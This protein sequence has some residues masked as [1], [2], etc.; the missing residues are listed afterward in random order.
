LAVGSEPAAVRIH[1]EVPNHL[2]P[3]STIPIGHG[4]DAGPQVAPQTGL[5]LHLAEGRRG[6]ILAVI[7]LALGERP[8][9]VPRTMHE[10]HRSLR[11]LAPQDDASRRADG[12]AHAQ[13]RSRLRESAFHASGDAARAS[14]A[15]CASIAASSPAT[16]ASAPP[17]AASRSHA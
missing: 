7:E 16:N 14:A 5:L 15:A 1:P 10:G 3:A 4:A 12:L 8:I 6:L 13:K 11:P 17:F 9:V 2:G